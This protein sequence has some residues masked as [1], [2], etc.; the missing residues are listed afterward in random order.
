MA[1]ILHC[2]PHLFLSNDMRLSLFRQD[3]FPVS[4]QDPE[5][6][7][8]PEPDLL[9]PGNIRDIPLHDPAH[10]LSQNI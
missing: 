3:S 9:E 1:D 10:I 8:R 4:A 6:L 7:P 5:R 2:L